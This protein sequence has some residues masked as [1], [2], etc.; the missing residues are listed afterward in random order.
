MLLK[1]KV[2]IVTGSSRGIGKA[3]ALV[4]AQA[5]AAVAVVARTEAEGGRLPGTIYETVKEIQARGGRA[6]AIKTDL[7]KDE[8]IDSMVAKAVVE[9]GRL[10]ILVNNAGIFSAWNFVDTSPRR[11]DLIMNTNLRAA[12][13]CTRAVLPHML[14]QS[15]GSIINLSSFVAKGARLGGA[16]IVYSVSKAGIERFTQDLA[17]ELRDANISVNALSPRYALTEGA[18]IFFPDTD[19]SSWQLP[20]MWGKYAVLVA[21]QDPKKF[22]GRI[23]DEAEAKKEFG[24][25]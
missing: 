15:R 6:L 17:W 4:M 22:T 2:A 18:K 14:K 20:E 16:S 1:D 8:D 9:L 19:T 24:P 13:L 23:L 21:A 12:F 5:G 10:D 3:I 11:W 25:V 7:T